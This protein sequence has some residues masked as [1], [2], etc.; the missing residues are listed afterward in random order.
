MAFNGYA[1]VIALPCDDGRRLVALR[2][3]PVAACRGV[4]MSAPAA[5]G[6]AAAAHQLVWFVAPFL[7]R[8]VWLIRRGT[9]TPRRANAIVLRYA[10][11]AGAVFVLLNVL[12]RLREPQA[13][14]RGVLEPLAEAAVPHGQCLVTFLL[15]WSRG[16]GNVAWF[17]L[18][19]GLDLA[20]GRLSMAFL[21]L[22]VGP[23]C[24]RCPPSFSWFPCSPIDN[25]SRPTALVAA[26]RGFFAIRVGEVPTRVPTAWQPPAVHYG[27]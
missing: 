23:D 4:I 3:V 6:M 26:E 22:R 18:C 2:S 12:F 1:S 7:L 27:S 10:A 20:A 9:T 13:W 14:L 24:W 5:L 16:S 19:R 17:S 25:R 21:F 15:F 8:G 11:V